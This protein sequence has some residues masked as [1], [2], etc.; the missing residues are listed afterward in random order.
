[1]NEDDYINPLMLNSIPRSPIKKFRPTPP[2]GPVLIKKGNLHLCL[3]CNTSSPFDFQLSLTKMQLNY[4]T[5]TES[6][7]I[8]SLKFITIGTNR[9]VDARIAQ[10]QQV[11]PLN[12]CFPLYPFSTFN[13]V[14]A[15]LYFNKNSR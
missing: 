4:M 13:F 12:R 8:Y 14:H 3:S 11:R 1:M 6:Y 10:R 9:L 7:K 2:V 5:T 15:A